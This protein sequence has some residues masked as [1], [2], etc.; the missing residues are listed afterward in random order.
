MTVLTPKEYEEQD[1]LDELYEAYKDEALENFY[2]DAEVVAQK[3][4]HM[5]NYIDDTV[6]IE[7]VLDVALA[8]DKIL[9]MGW[10]YSFVVEHRTFEYD[11]KEQ[12]ELFVSDHLGFSPKGVI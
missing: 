5:I 4:E 8:I 9:E 7:D 12:A 6:N 10:Y 3:V 2:E 1:H 11:F